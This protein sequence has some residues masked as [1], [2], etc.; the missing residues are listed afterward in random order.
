MKVLLILTVGIFAASTFAT[1]T[2]IDSYSGNGQIQWDDPNTNGKYRVEWSSSLAEG[3]TSS[4][5]SLLNIKATG[6]IMT[7]SSPMFYRV[8]W[9][10]NQV[11]SA[12]FFETFED[13]MAWSDKSAGNWIALVDT[14][15]WTSK[16][17]YAISNPV[18]AH[19]GNRYI[20][21]SGEIEL[22][23]TDN[24]TQVVVWVRSTAPG[25]TARIGLS[26]FDGVSWQLWYGPWISGNIYTQ[27]VFQLNLGYPNPQQRLKLDCGLGTIYVDDVSVQCAP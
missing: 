25:A 17:A 18:N 15:T 11:S 14:G 3:W 8:L 1:D 23:R 13:E 4:W 21:M 19:S 2:E 22:P 10:S 24:P 5:T 7:A 6:G 16:G 27:Q 9:I 26:Y 12:G 20:G